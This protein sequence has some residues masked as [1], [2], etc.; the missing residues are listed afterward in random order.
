MQKSIL[1]IRKE[2][3]ITAPRPGVAVYAGGQA[4]TRDTGP[5]LLET[6]ALEARHTGPKPFPMMGYYRPEISLRLSSDNGRTWQILGEPIRQPMN[7]VE[8]ARQFDPHHFRDPDNGR[9]IRFFLGSVI[10]A[11]L[12]HA[13]SFSDAGCEGRSR[14]M[15]YRVSADQGR[16]WGPV[17]QV[18]CAGAEYDETHWGP[19]LFFMRTGGLYGVGPTLKAA[20]GAVVQS[21]V[22]QLFDGRG[23]QSGLL[24]GRWNAANTDLTWTFSD[25]ITV[26]PDQ[27]SQGCC[28]PAPA[29]LDDGR[30]FISLRCCGDKKD[31]TFP[32]LKF[33]VISADGGQ[34]FS[35]PQ[36][37][38][39]TDGR[40]VWSPSSMAAV[41]RSS[42]NRRYYWIGNILDAPTYGSGPRHP[43]CIAELLPEKGQLLR[44]TV[45]VIDTLPPDWPP[46]KLARPRRY[47]N[48]GLYE[49]RLTREVV[50]TLPEQPRTDWE[51][52]TADCYCYRIALNQP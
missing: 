12:A 40:P 51:D 13:E 35:T 24:H 5:E 2:L 41:I 42:V 16:N 29:L 11:D 30:I 17:R 43:L 4:Y 1:T 25:Y 6:V 52:F 14:R 19:G 44:E 26:P 31:Q 45:A 22:L 3:Y 23:Y 27:S 33:W 36:P 9:I 7:H 38:T 10:R 50:L 47:T 34:T 39:Y 28:E 32:S 8:G 18:I 49:D 46:E 15:F 20:D 21:V 37:L 48:F